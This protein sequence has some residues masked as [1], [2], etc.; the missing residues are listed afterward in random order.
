MAGAPAGA[1]RPAPR[2]LIQIYDH[3]TRGGTPFVEPSELRRTATLPPRSSE[4]AAANIITAA[5]RRPVAV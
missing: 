4:C 1:L 2:G 3:A 5:H